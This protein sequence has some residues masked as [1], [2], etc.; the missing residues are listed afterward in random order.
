M[1][2]KFENH[3]IK[4]V[5]K[6]TPEFKSKEELWLRI[7]K[8]SKQDKHLLYHISKYAAIFIGFISLLGLLWYANERGSF[9]N[10]DDKVSVCYLLDKETQTTHEKIMEQRYQLEKISESDKAY[11][12]VFFEELQSLQQEYQQYTKDLSQFEAD[13]NI[14]TYIRENEKQQLKIL[15]KLF[16]EL[17][18]KQ[19]YEQAIKQK[20]S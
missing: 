7:N 8:N 3:I 16:K 6:G 1:T 2:D 14:C 5:E 10:H 13:R 4:S 12:L 11:L 17:K 19:H 9:F 15:S 18:N 20:H